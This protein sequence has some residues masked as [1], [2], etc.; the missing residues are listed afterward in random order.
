[1]KNK[2]VLFWAATISVVSSTLI[3]CNKDFEQAIPDQSV[4][5]VK[6]DSGSNGLFSAI[7]G[8]DGIVKNGTFRGRPIKYIEYNGVPLYQGDIL[9]SEQDLAP[10]ANRPNSR[11]EAAVFEGNARRWEH[12]IVPYTIGPDIDNINIEIAMQ[13]WSQRTPIKFVPRKG[14]FNYISFVKDTLNSSFVG[15]KGGMQEIRL[16][17]GKSIGVIIHEIGHALGLEHEQNRHDRNDYVDFYP[18]NLENPKLKSQYEIES[19]TVDHGKFD[20]NS[21]MLYASTDFAK[22]D[23]VTKE[24][25]A[26]L[27]RKDNSTF[28]GHKNQSAPSSG[29]EEAIR[30]MYS[31]VYLVRKDVLHSL[32]SDGRE[33]NMGNGWLGAA[34]NLGE[35]GQFIWGIQD[36]KLWKTNR[37]NGK[38][39]QVGNGNWNG[40]IGVTGKDPQGNLY[41]QAGDYLWKIDKYGVHRALGNSGWKGTKAM[42]HVNGWL[43]VIWKNPYL[44]S[45]A[46]L[47]KVNTTTGVYN[48]LGTATFSNFQAMTA[49]NR[50]ATDLYI[51]EGNN[52]LKINT[53]TGHSSLIRLGGFRNTTAMAGHA[54]HLYVASDGSVL[55]VNLDGVTVQKFAGYD[56]VT[57]MGA[58][59]IVSF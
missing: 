51:V 12:N 24:K 9:L 13:K 29:D 4:A 56:G 59:N 47:Y 18:E 55:K 58:V 11:T 41:A 43:Y 30:A 54:G 32:S 49:M 34:Q 42:Y 16:I 44:N 6:S 21:I 39:Q 28:S 2:A 48:Q 17:N 22:T 25:L 57:S 40:A 19:T 36:G 7:E 8:K 1:M 31:Y 45:P 35:D 23:P 37:V 38:Y 3:S 15:M 27:R 53:N 20:F 10:D 5:T 46:V 52:L 50:L 26:V 14:E 33:T